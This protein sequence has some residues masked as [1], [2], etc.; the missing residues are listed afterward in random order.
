MTVDE[1][2][3]FFDKNKKICDRIKVLQDVGLGYIKLGQSAN[4]LSGGEAQRVKLASYLGA[5]A[6]EYAE[7]M[8]FIFDEPTTGLHA[9]DI[10]KLLKSLNALVEQKNT[11]LVIEHNM[12]VISQA[13]W[14][15]DLGPEGGINGGL[16]C[17]EGTPAELTLQKNNY[18]AQF[19][20]KRLLDK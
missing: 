14:V 18:T 7:N 12:E 6:S 9:H 19:L 5:G 4:T 10:S 17:F 13:D 20:T 16:I 11:V 15:I 2:V 8:V 3:S 1:A